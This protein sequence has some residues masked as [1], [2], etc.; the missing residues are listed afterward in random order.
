MKILIYG[1][2]GWI[3]SQFK[4]ILEN[5]NINYIEGKSR[6]DNE[7]ELLQEI[8]KINPTH[9][10]SFIGRTHGKIGDKEYSTIDYLEEKG[11]IFENVRDNLFSPLI[12][13]DICKK[14]DIHFTYL[15]TGC[16]FTFD[17]THPYEQEVNG[18]KE[19]SK[20]NFFGSGYSI[21]K[22]FTDRLMKIYADSTL[23]LRIRMPITGEKN[24]RNFITK[25]TNYKN[26]C[27]IKNSM[28]VLPKLL[29]LIVKLM[30]DKTVGTLNFT[31][32]GLISH[33]EILEMYK[34]I[35]DPKFTWE[36]FSKE[37]QSKIL[38]S[39]RSNNYLNTTRLETLFPEVLNIK[40]SVRNVLYEYKNTTYKINKKYLNSI[41]LKND[42]KEYFGEWINNIDILKEK[43]RNAFPFEHIKI[44]N[45]LQEDY[46]EEIYK[47]FPT[48]FENWH[49]YWNPIEVKY[50]ND[51]INNMD[52]LIK[53]IFYLLST[54]KLIKVFSQITGITD[55]E[56]DPYLHGAGLHV[57]PRY[58]RLNMH[59]DYEKH[60]KLIN[61]QRR[62][63]IIL[64][65]TKDWKQEWNGDNQLWNKDMKECIV[66]TYPKFNSA[67]IFKTDELSWHGL[68]EKI[69]CPE[70]TFRKSLAY[71]YISPLVNK[72]HEYKI[73]NDGSG[74]RTKATFVKRPEEKDNERMKKLY[75][76]RPHSRIEKKDMEEIW[77][78]WTP[79]LF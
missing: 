12:L 13:A 77:P 24:P 42:S 76:I 78:E 58:G 31:N 64:F 25:I 35:V 69:T 71:Y 30:K 66:K 61:K 16:I 32:P 67:I 59:L 36:N 73:G 7:I 55:L 17:E 22:G 18:F 48:D 65:L 49:K 45:F 41:N 57:H 26:I 53:D 23:T 15:G 70:G 33:N 19:E 9:I 10:I 56:Y 72:K 3:G 5:Q 1:S 34:E 40:D 20:P 47:N 43:Y 74:F 79:K 11:K 62:L 50:A 63:N 39:D 29:P 54:D 2:R 8:V 14:Q 44:E 6:V 75:K 21:L 60:P 4:E 51:D 38:T 46:A 68:P 37:E 27:S 28:T 52:K